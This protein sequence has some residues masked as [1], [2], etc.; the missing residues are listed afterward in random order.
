MPGGPGRGAVELDTTLYLPE[1]TPAPAVLVAH[2]FGG[3][4]ASVDA[5]A[6]DLA[7]RGFVV[8]AWSAR[9]FGASGGQIALDAPDYEVADARA[10]VDWLAARPEVVQD[11]PG[12]PRVGVTGGSYGGALSLLLAGLRPPGRRDRP[13]DHLERPGAGA[14]PQRRRRARRRRRTPRPAARS[15]RTG[16]SSA[17]GPGSSSRPGS[18][19]RRPGSALEP[20]SG[21]GSTGGGPTGAGRPG[22]PSRRDDRRRP[23]ADAAPATGPGTGPATCGR[24]VPAVCA[25]Y[26]E[27]ATTGRLSPAHRRAAAPLVP[28][29]RHRPDHRAH[30][31][32]AGRAGHPVRPRP[33]RRQRP[34]DRRAPAPRSRSPGSP[35]GTTAAG[36][37]P[38]RPRRDRRLVHLVP[39]PGRRAGRR[40]ED[41]GTGFSYAVESGIRASSRTPTG[42]TVVAAAY[43]GLPGAS[44]WTAADRS[45]CRAT[46]RS[47]SARPGGNPA[48]IT[49]LPGLGGAL[50]SVGGRLTAITAELPGQSAQFRSRALRRRRCWWRARRGSP[51]R[52]PGCPGSRRR[53]RRCCSP[54]PTRSPRT[55]C[56]RCWAA[57]WRRCGSRCPPTGRPPT[58]T[59]TLPGVV[60]PI[61]AGNRL[62]VSVSTTDQGY[63]GDPDPAVWRIGLTGGAVDRAGGARRGGHGQHRAARAGDRHRRGARARAARLARPVALL[64]RR[65]PA[66]RRR[67]GQRPP[68]GG[69]ATWPRPTRAGS[70]R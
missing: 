11:G 25:A 12:D 41:P 59:V 40:G 29:Q 16:C 45:R 69:R 2:G 28:G 20:G 24:F 36:S 21:A 9:G 54:R 67:P 18:A 19:R 35:A 10:L 17:A 60:A 33:G 61:E 51:S 58:V 42:R 22:P 15:R 55:A 27:A 5:D 43:P 37:G 39:R 68:A 14:V 8:L 3:S 49:S 56:A 31:A 57:R 46:R 52:S 38:A 7:A 64:L 62:L 34:P 13:G 47:C 23:A 53:P 65:R 44:A 1:T 66:A 48:A 4:K 6:R 30:A 32:R 70:A 63:A 26:T 50:G